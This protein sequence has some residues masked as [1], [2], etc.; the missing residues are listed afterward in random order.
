MNSTFQSERL[1]FTPLKEA[2]VSAV[3]A[4]HSFEDVAAF[5]TIGIPKDIAA[6][7][8]VLARKINPDDKENLGWGIRDKHQNFIG[9]L[10]LILAPPRFK[11]GEISYSIHPEHWGKGYATEALYTGLHYAFNALHLLRV[12]AGVAVHNK[13]SIRVLEKGRM[14]REGRHQK[15]LPLISGWSDHFSYAILSADFK[16]LKQ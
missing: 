4:L 13:K 7:H 2:D 10:G 14:K 11:K 9:E 8:K 1:L 15:T 12:E 3:H 16:Q 6:T 5:N